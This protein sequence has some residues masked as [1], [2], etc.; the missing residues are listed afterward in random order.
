MYI[1]ATFLLK[2]YT[3]LLPPPP[4]VHPLPP[5]LGWT[6]GC[7]LPEQSCPPR[8]APDAC[9]PCCWT[10]PPTHTPGAASKLPSPSTRR[11]RVHTHTHLV[12]LPW[13]EPG[14]KCSV[15]A[16][17]LSPAFFSPHHSNIRALT[18]EG[19]GLADVSQSLFGT[20]FRTPLPRCLTSQCQ[21]STP[22]VNTH[23][24]HGYCSLDILLLSLQI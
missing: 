17:H 4:F 5:R 21:I 20:P 8:S 16:V 11:P 13:C 14:V 1:P 12:E 23:T 19:A 15:N 2:F 9:P 10:S 6:A 7:S 22:L 3:I 18:Q 24:Q